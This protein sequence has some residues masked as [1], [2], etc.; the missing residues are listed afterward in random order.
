MLFLWDGSVGTC[1]DELDLDGGG[2]R[3][4][5]VPVEESNDGSCVLVAGESDDDE[6]ALVDD[7]ETEIGGIEKERKGG[8]VSTGVEARRVREDEGKRR[9]L[10]ARRTWEWQ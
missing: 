5:V 7:A 9:K 3:T 8:E 4:E 2:L 10:R 6:G 1:D